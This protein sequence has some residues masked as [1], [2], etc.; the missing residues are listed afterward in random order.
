MFDRCLYFNVNAFARVVNKKWAK[1]FEQ[2]ELSPAHGYMLRAVLSEPGISQKHLA[3][4]LR[5]DKSTVTRF[6]DSLQKQGFVVRK[7]SASDARE[8]SIMPTAKAK[9]IHAA[10]EELGENL[11]QSVLSNVGAKDLELLIAQLRQAARK[12][13]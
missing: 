6:I 5:L 1:A 13:E 11:Y 2:Y 10:L 3:E 8:H 7:K 12:I 4:A 9:K